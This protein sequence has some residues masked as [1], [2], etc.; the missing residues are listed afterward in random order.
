M[1]LNFKTRLALFNALAAA[2]S[3]FFVF[4][5]IYTI[6]YV[7]AYK[8]LDNDILKEKTDVLESIRLEN[9]R[10]LVTQKLEWEEREHR[11]VVVNPT[12]VQI[13]GLQGNLI[14]QSSNLKDARL[15]IITPVTAPVFFDAS[16]EGKR[17]REG[18]FIISD[19]EQQAIGVLNIGVSLSETDLILRNLRITL[20]LS[21]L[22]LILVLFGAS[23]FAAARGIKPIHKIIAT[24]AGIDDQHL[25][26]RL[27]LPQRRDELY[28]LAMAINELLERIESSLSRE[29]QI[30]ADLSH[31]L[32]TP[33]TGIRGT[34]EVLLRQRRTPEQYETKLAYLLEETDRLHKLLEQILQLARLESGN[35][36]VARSPI[37]LYGQIAVIVDNWLPVLQ[38]KRAAVEVLIPPGILVHADAVLLEIMLGNLL[39]NAVKY[40][41][42]AVHIKIRWDDARRCLSVVDN[43]PGI[44]AEQL[45]HIFDRF[46]RGDRARSARVQGSGLGLAI[47]QKTA[48]LQNITLQ[49]TSKEGEGTVFN[50]LF[51]EKAAQS[52]S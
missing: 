38:E 51:A 17:I 37:D 24:A 4:V 14:F 16:F 3:T 39:S 15:E 35:V 2:I 18:Q 20:G 50:M 40:G 45:P 29:K 47:V 7:T 19:P 46:Y 10:V 49:V 13:S 30:T 41:Q 9:N 6:V 52:F 42:E 44:P 8:H 5:A 1:N 23:S 26:T 21:F 31:E 32:R 48:E 25:Q 34:L 36:N 33:L 11:Q 27:P 22:L 43:G 12:F 28:Q